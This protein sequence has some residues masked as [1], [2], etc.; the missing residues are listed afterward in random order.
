MH[1]FRSALILVAVITLPLVGFFGLQ[2]D[3]ATDVFRFLTNNDSSSRTAELNA[4][5]Q[6]IQQRQ[7]AKQDL[8][9]RLADGQ[10]NREEALSAYAEILSTAPQYVSR[11]RDN[12]PTLAD[13]ELLVWDLSQEVEYRLEDQPELK[14]LALAQLVTPSQ[15]TTSNTVGLDESDLNPPQR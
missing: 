8:V 11:L 10:V 5:L 6:T 14:S 15:R 7:I 1:L 12:N 3:V 13:A 9:Y 4:Q 2:P